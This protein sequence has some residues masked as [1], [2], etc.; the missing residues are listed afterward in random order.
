M[1]GMLCTEIYRVVGIGCVDIACASGQVPHTAVH[2]CKDNQGVNALTPKAAVSLHRTLKSPQ[3]RINAYGR[4]IECTLRVVI[5][6][7]VAPTSG[8][9][10]TAVSNDR[11]Y[12]R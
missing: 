7:I 3:Q 5:A 1:R 2:V 11:Q 9:A 10:G 8:A 4:T 6:N 12:G